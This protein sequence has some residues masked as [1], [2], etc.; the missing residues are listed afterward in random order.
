M[1]D[2]I[3]CVCQ[4]KAESLKW[5][6]HL[7]QQIKACRQPSQAANMSATSLV[8]GNA[9]SNPVGNLGNPPPPPHVSYNHQPFEL[10]TVNFS[11]SISS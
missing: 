8:G 2:R 7:R 10:L 4:T 1:I 9:G 5:V 3:L 11:F 6:E